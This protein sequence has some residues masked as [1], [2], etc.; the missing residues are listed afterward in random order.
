[1]I[2]TC[3]P[4][5]LCHQDGFGGFQLQFAIKVTN[6]LIATRPCTTVEGCQSIWLYGVGNSLTG[7]SRSSTQASR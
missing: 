6:S 3:F 7:W 4:L 2:W 1:M 5:A